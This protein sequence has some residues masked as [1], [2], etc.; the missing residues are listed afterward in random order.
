MF[1]PDKQDFSKDRFRFSLRFAIMRKALLLTALSL[2]VFSVT[3]QKEVRIKENFDFGWKFRLDSAHSAM[4]PGVSEAGWEEIQLPHDWSI[5]F[6]FDRKAGGAAGFLP[7]GIGAYRKS[8]F[9]PA[10]Y[11]GK[12]ISVLFDGVYHQSKVYING[13]FLGFHPYGYTGFGYDLTPFL[14]FGGE[15][16]LTVRVDHSDSPSSRWY[17]GSGIYRHAWL[18]IVSPV[19]VA[20][21]GTYIT[22]PSVTASEADVKIV[23]TVVNASEKPQTVIVSQKIMDSGNNIIAENAGKK[24]TVEAKGNKDIEHYLQISNPRLWTLEE[25]ALYTMITTIKEGGRIVDIYS[26]SFGVRTFKFDKD[27][28][29]SLNGKNI[30]LKGMCL[31]HDAGSLGTAV[32]DRSYE[33]RLEILKEFGCNAIRCSHNP[34]SPE[35]LDMCDRMGFIVIDE[36]F[37]KWKSG[38]YA[39]YFDEWWQRDLGDMLLRDRNHP[40]VFLWSIGNEV[41]ESKGG[42]ENVNRAK[43]LQDFVHRTDPTR[44]VCVALQ[45]GSAQDFASV[46]DVIGYNYLEARMLED[47]KKYPERIFVIT[48]ALPYFSSNDA[49]R[50]RTYTPVNPW[51]YVADNDYLAGQFLWVGADYLGEATWPSKGWPSGLF[52]LCMFEKPRASFHRAVWNSKPIVTIAV[53][54]Q[55]LNIDPPRD[56]WQWPNLAGH[57][58]FPQ[59][60]DG[61]MVEVRTTTN[62]ESVELFFNGSS[63]GR[64][65]TSD[66]TN[67]TIVWYVPY[68]AGTLEAKAFTGDREEATYKLVTSEGADHIIAEPDRKVIKADGQDL[69]HIA[70]QLYDKK[71]IPVQTDDRKLTVTMEGEGRFLG[72][73]NGETR[74]EKSFAGNQLPTYFGRALVIVQSTRKAGTMRVRIDMEGSEE[75]VI[76]DIQSR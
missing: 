37:D 16:L 19:H 54:D 67:N 53:A 72:I 13:H 71:G 6:D 55:S 52:D 5:K 31:H 7:G 33:R 44:P 32:P 18:Q 48:E 26:T 8:F 15:N 42:P 51:Y 23:T 50:L 43:M 74:R 60:S 46:T 9:I 30:K 70:I 73:D 66:Y 38:Y 4:M 64:R 56:L 68:R 36:A 45:N 22:T 25:S 12:K 27:K 63:M 49:T 21:W 17:S 28:G 58:N 76:V 47:R 34:P 59:Y 75:P 14:N 24:I 11:R 2:F 3:A 29:F 35:F 10:S 20:T 65:K 1:M 61:R 41:A 57:W 62:C 39:K 69:S 40:S